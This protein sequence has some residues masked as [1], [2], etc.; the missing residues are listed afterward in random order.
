[1]ETSPAAGRLTARFIAG[2]TLEREVAVCQRLNA[3]GYLATLDHLGESVT[4]LKEAEQSR[5]SYL[6]ALDQIARLNL[7]A[8]VS[9]KLTQLGLDFSE[10]AGRAAVECLVARAKGMGRMVAVDME[11]S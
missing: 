2:S 5:D 1:M 7:Q 10:P 4:S 6:V 11:T 8:T 3:D 9:I